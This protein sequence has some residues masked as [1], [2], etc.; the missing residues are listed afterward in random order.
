LFNF[1]IFQYSLSLY[2]ISV[3]LRVG[4]TMNSYLAPLPN[5]R[6]SIDCRFGTIIVTCFIQKFLTPPSRGYKF[7]GVRARWQAAII[8]QSQSEQRVLN[9]MAAIGNEC[10]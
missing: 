10:Q 6:E 4:L 5:Y 2:Y 3:D 9:C 7:V 1:R 8:R